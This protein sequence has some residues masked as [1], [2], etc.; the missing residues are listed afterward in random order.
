MLLNRRRK[1]RGVATAPAVPLQNVLASLG[2]AVILT[3]GEARITLFNQAAEE[4]TGVPEAQALQCTCSEL[5][6]ATPALAA[7]VERTRNLM[8]SQSC[9]EESLAVGLR[10]VP[11]R[12]SCSPI[13]GPE[14]DVHGVALVVQDLSYQKKL[15]DEARRNETLARLGGLVAGLAHEVKNPLGGIKG[16]AQLLAKRKLT[17]THGFSNRT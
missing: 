1:I 4:L 7:M 9:G 8:Q 3:D 13:W 5:F 6:S 11:V 12:V 2:D 17:R 15:E 14:G 16:A 10:R